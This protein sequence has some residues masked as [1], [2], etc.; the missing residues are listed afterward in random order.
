MTEIELNRLIE[1]VE[2]VPQVDLIPG[3]GRYGVFRY[4]AKLDAN[5]RVADCTPEWAAYITA[6]SPITVK[7][8]LIAA[9]GNN[10]GSV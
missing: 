6:L 9:R 2:S 4:D 10:G 3:K 1:I 7:R 5:V 8:L